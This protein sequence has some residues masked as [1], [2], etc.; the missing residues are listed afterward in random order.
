MSA[1]SQERL[2]ER[3][4]SLT[5]LSARKTFSKLAILVIIFLAV[6][7][8]FVKHRNH[9]LDR[10]YAEAAGDWRFFKGSNQSEDA[11]AK[12][13]EYQGQRSTDLLLKL[14]LGEGPFVWRSVQ[15]HAI[16]ALGRRKDPIVANQL[17]NLL[18]PH[19]A[20]DVREAVAEALQT[21]PC[22]DE[23]NR[24]I[25]FYLE[26]IWAGELNREDRTII[27]PVFG[28]ITYKLHNEQA[29]MYSKLYV[30][31]ER[32]RH[33]TLTNLVQLH[34][35]GTDAPSTFSLDLLSRVKIKEACPLLIASQRAIQKE[36]TKTYKAPRTEIES[37]ITSLN[38]K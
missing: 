12:L 11:V 7:F 25:L 5:T 6:V 22:N 34:G 32:E 29:E 27:P 28:D 19:E 24:A 4:T 36:P 26:R 23:C 8:V 15:T 14:S 17:S 33:E 1:E 9:E 13:S 3:W 35:L 38:C 16:R 10:L 20:L 31:L 18:Q 2:R 37:V 30:I 21:L